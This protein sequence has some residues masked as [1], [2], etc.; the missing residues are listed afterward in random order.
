MA[1]FDLI[2]R[3]TVAAIGNATNTAR[4]AVKD[5]SEFSQSV[6]TAT[7]E[8][9]ATIYGAYQDIADKVLG[10]PIDGESREDDA[11]RRTVRNAFDRFQ[12]TMAGEES[13]AREAKHET[14]PAPTEDTAEIARKAA[15][16]A[17]ATMAERKSAA[18]KA[19][20]DM[21]NAGYVTE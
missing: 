7:S 20:E 13:D 18:A 19:L 4:A 5:S 6:A 14:K 1:N 17:R 15:E 21:L 12:R 9:V 3:T 10:L 8:Y 2:T 16:T 11:R